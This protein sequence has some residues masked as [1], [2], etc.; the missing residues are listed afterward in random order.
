[1]SAARKPR[2]IGFSGIENMRVA[3][4]RLSADEAWT[5]DVGGSQ[6]LHH[7]GSSNSSVA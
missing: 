5:V 4:N 6:T 3:V 7:S 1:M 2:G